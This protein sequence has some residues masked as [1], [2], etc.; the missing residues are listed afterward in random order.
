MHTI[1]NKILKNWT[2]QRLLFV[3]IGIMLLYDAYFKN[4]WLG[5]FIGLYFLGIGFFSIAC[6]SRNCF[7]SN[8]NTNSNSANKLNSN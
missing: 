3:G 5:Y 6:V 1:K 4:E 7:G 8:C 2:L